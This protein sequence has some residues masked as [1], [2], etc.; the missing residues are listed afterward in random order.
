[1]ESGG[2]LS[3]T[4]SDKKKYVYIQGI[5]LPGL[6]YSN[7]LDN[8]GNPIPDATNA[9]QK[10]HSPKDGGIDQLD[11]VVT[12]FL[13]YAKSEYE[14]IK[15]VAEKNIN[16]KNFKE[17][18]KRFSSLLGVWEDVYDKDGNWTGEQ[19]ISFNDN[20]KSWE[21]NLGI[22]EAYFF[23]RSEDEQKALIKRNLN[24]I[25]DKELAT[26][27]SLGLI[28]RSGSNENVYLNYKNIIWNLKK[29]KI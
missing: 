22:A 17:Q 21:E 25:L 28:K 2:I 23:D 14:S 4:L 12:Q 5:K 6:D 27:E 8:E 13:S 3:L 11:S 24:K 20:K 15:S 9:I 29:K 26:A 18:G 19:F 7:V 16:V 1:M 10:T